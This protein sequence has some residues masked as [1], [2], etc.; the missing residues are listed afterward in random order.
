MAEWEREDRGA[1][2]SGL[3]GRC[4]GQIQDRRVGRF[5]QCDADY[6][7][8]VADGLGIPSPMAAATT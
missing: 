5:A 3:L 6:G 2:M 8:R 1:N 7:A 4:E